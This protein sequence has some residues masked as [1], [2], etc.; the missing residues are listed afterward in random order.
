VVDANLF[1]LDHP[2]TKISNVASRVK[3][4]INQLVTELEKAHGK[5]A[6]IEHTSP[7]PGDIRNFDI[8]PL[9]LEKHGFS[10]KGGFNVQT[11]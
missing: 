5:T 6:M 4:S 10:I 1:C 7:L 11:L 3:V 9:A 2:E 8:G